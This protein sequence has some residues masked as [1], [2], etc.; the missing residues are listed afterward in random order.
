MDKVKIVT[1]LREI[2]N[3]QTQVRT[4]KLKP[5]IEELYKD[6]TAPVTEEVITPNTDPEKEIDRAIKNLIKNFNIPEDKALE[7]IQA[8]FDAG[9]ENRYLKRRL[10]MYDLKISKLEK[11][12]KELKKQ[13][14]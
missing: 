10:T 11:E 12:I 1:E 5:M 13:G 14:K 4:N 3:N 6:I 2:V 8:G 9:S 7:V